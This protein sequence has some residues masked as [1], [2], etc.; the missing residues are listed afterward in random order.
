MPTQKF[1]DCSV[2]PNPRAI[3]KLSLAS[4][5]CWSALMGPA[6]AAEELNKNLDEATA[7]E[8]KDDA[9]EAE[10]ARLQSVVVTSQ[11]RAEN[12]QDVPIPITVIGGDKI[13]DTALSSA[14]QIGNYIPN[15][16]AERNNGHGLPRWNLRGLYTG[17]PS[18]TTVSPLG[19]Y[20]D[21]I[22]IS[23]VTAANRPLFD[24][25]R[26]E[27]SRGPQ[28]TL[29]GRNSTGGALNFI[30]KKPTFEP[31]GY[32]KLDGGSYDRRRIEGAIG[33]AILDER[34]AGRI[35]FYDENQDG[36][37]KNVFGGDSRRG[38]LEDQAF[39]AQLLAKLS[40]NLDTLLTMHH[41]E[42]KTEGVLARATRYGTRANGADQYGFIGTPG[43]TNANIN[44]RAPLVTQE[45]ISNRLNWQ[46]GK[47]ELTSITAFDDYRSRA[48]GDTDGEG[49]PYDLQRSWAGVQRSKQISQEL[50]L[51][52]P[53]EDR[54]NWL[55][56]FHYFREDASQSSA[57]ASLPNPYTANNF[58]RLGWDQKTTSYAFFGSNTF[59]FTDKL[60][61]TSGLRWSSETK[62]INL[63]RRTSSNATFSNLNQWWN[64]SSVS[65]PL[66]TAAV[67]DEEKTWRDWSWDITPAYKVNDN[68]RVYFRYARGFLSGGFNGGANNQQAVG[69]VNPEYLTDYEVGLKSEWLDGR[70][71]FNAN[72]FYYDYKDIQTNVQFVFNNRYTSFRTNG[73]KGKV[74]GTEFELS[75]LPL[76]KLR[77]NAALSRLHTEY[78]DFVTANG[79]DYTGDE[80]GRSP[81]YSL[82]LGANYKIPLAGKNALVFD[83]NWNCRSPQWLSIDHTNKAFR[84]DSRVLGQAS[85]SYLIND[86]DI[87]LTAYV[88]NITDKRYL[89]NSAPGGYNTGNFTYAEPRTVG[90]SL[91]KQ[92]F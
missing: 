70:L 7:K 65:S 83:T 64:Y 91:T 68:L 28:G 44:G 82:I 21:D 69:L 60:N 46:L 53:R 73:A 2:S 81:K 90:F 43:L 77:V 78:T 50:R 31:D 39:R 92:F 9:R 30:S 22:Y 18:G 49:G 75:A 16:S 34:L 32:V 72:A 13:K 4:L 62:S 12:A 84:D 63:L 47:L 15:L 11:K 36:F 58:D 66:V 17:D 29:W 33:G 6:W 41:R 87:K 54:W 19:V 23:N 48:R 80:F 52:S 10:G 8:A 14:S 20:Y 59:N 85:V 27:V 57:S 88:D 51:A 35:A 55:A 42:Y 40:E 61:L 3:F 5:L 1:S 45:G 37:G 76:D 71:N 67:Q 26:V 24:L 56:G 89:A 86:G 79:T 38:K 74:W 25:E